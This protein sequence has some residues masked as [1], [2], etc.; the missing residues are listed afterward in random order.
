MKEP[1]QGPRMQR[2]IPSKKGRRQRQAGIIVRVLSACV[3]LSLVSGIPGRALQTE[4][5]AATQAQTQGLPQGT[6]QSWAE[7]AARNEVAIIRQQGTFSVRYLEHKIDSKGDT[8]RIVIESKQGGVARLIQRNGKPISRSE[9]TAERARLQYDLD[10][11]EDFLR[12]HRKDGSWRANAIQVVQLMPQAMINTFGPGQPQPP[13]AT[14]RQVVLDYR[15]NPK[16]HPPTMLADLLTG[17]EGRVWID[18]ETQRVTRIEGHVLHPVDFGL[19]VVA[20]LAPGGTLEFEQIDAG[21][22]H[23]MYSHL[24]EHIV[25]RALMVKTMPENVEDSS[26]QVELLP[27]LLSYQDAIRKLLAPTPPVP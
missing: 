20:R 18:A 25:V 26:S 3:L 17:I 8:V 7:A 4:T 27:S 24:S 10:H 12:H 23:W 16:F 19:G 11:P 15:P 14:T 6:P 1:T 2:A 22:G 21:S 13:G 9:D 5:Q